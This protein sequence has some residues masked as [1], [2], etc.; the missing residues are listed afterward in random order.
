MSDDDSGSD[1]EYLE[2]ESQKN[3]KRRLNNES[4]GDY[5]DEETDD[6]YSSSDDDEDYQDENTNTSNSNKNKNKAS[7][8]KDKK[9]KSLQ[10]ELDSAKAKIKK[11][12][13][14]NK[15]LKQQLKAKQSGTKAG[16]AKNADKI[17]KKYYKKWAVRLPK[18]ANMKKTKYM[19][20]QGVKPN[21]EIIIKEEGFDFDE[22]EILFKDKGYLVQPRPDNK[23]KSRVIIRRFSDWDEIKQIFGEYGLKETLTVHVYRKR[24]LAK[25]Q[26]WGT[27]EANITDLNVEYNKSSKRLQL[28]FIV[29]RDIPNMAG[30]GG[31]PFL[32]M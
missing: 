18:L 8:A 20:G 11:L 19:I 14:E 12:E 2:I 24:N 31:F 3:K 23:P 13:T 30:F 32:L 10:K 25:T 27:D 5:H 16:P 1:S 4:D 17:K 15:K 29:E 6:E 28:K 7:P 26:Y 22:F 21:K 9:I